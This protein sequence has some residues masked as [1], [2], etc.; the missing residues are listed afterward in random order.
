M[1]VPRKRFKADGPS[2]GGRFRAVRR[3]ITSSRTAVRLDLHHA[4]YCAGMTPLLVAIALGLGYLA[5]GVVAWALCRA[6]HAGD[7]PTRRIIAGSF[8]V[9][10]RDERG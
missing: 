5:S 7:D 1:R 4:A 6:A 2:G 10:A 3:E 8:A 9:I